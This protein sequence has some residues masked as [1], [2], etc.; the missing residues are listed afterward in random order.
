MHECINEC[1][2][3]GVL[4][5]YLGK[6]MAFKGLLGL[7][8]RGRLRWVQLGVRWG[9]GAFAADPKVDSYFFFW[10]GFAGFSGG[11]RK[12]FGKVFGTVAHK[13][14]SHFGATSIL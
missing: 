7:D 5:R 1:M 11:F 3:E 13:V 10:E 9:V 2:H 4:I 6:W 14:D 8:F 12:D